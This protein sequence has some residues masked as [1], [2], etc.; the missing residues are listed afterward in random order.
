MNPYT[1]RG[2]FA[3]D[4]LDQQHLT[5]QTVWQRTISDELIN[6]FCVEVLGLRYAHILNR[7]LFRWEGT[8]VENATLC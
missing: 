8:K 4:R 3:E 1:K 7:R 2:V 5:T 6:N